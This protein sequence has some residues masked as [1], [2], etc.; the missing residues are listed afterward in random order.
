VSDTGPAPPDGAATAAE[1]P[2]A[3]DKRTL[4]I[5]AASMVGLILVGVVSAQLFVRGGCEPLDDPVAADSEVVDA[6]VALTDLGVDGGAVLD[7][8]G[9]ALGAGFTV[10]VEVGDATGITTGTDGLVVTG[11]R[12]TALA[13]DGTPSLGLATGGDVV[14]SGD[15]L[16][17]LNL[18]NPGTGQVDGFTPV[19]SADL[20]AGAC[21]DTAVVG[22]AF[23][24]LLDAGDG[25]VLLFRS[26]EDGAAAVAQLRDGDTAAWDLPLSLPAGSPGVL[27][28]RLTGALGP[29]RVV[30]ARRVAPD[31]P[32]PV[33]I[34]A[35]RADGTPDVE[36]SRDEVV[37]GFD[38][39]DDVAVRVA[40]HAVDDQRALLSAA[41]DPAQADGQ[42]PAEPATLGLLDL[43]DGTIE[44]LGGTDGRVVEAALDGDRFAAVLADG[45]EGADG[46]D[47]GDG[48]GDG[49]ILYLGEL[50]S[51]A[52][53]TARLGGQ[54]VAAAFGDGAALVATDRVLAR[55][56]WVDPGRAV[57]DDALDQQTL[58]EGVEVRDLAVAPD[59][60]LLALVGTGDRQVLLAGGPTDALTDG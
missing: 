10:G 33:V 24:F 6:E 58:P 19:A 46:A 44:R 25:Q 13:V 26:E 59:G 32:D 31:D 20:R 47:D 2:L 1:D 48:D 49:V 3:A 17:A 57:Q 16:Y 54:H 41:P 23:A 11:P 8:L 45:G 43:D 52:P 4:T 29:D 42:A 21:T 35:G 22:E 53:A 12:T 36:V 9:T 38:L 51:G 18:A 50:G 5:G 14:G 28:D 7:T 27:A 39:A 40:V 37:A 56:G 55:V 60:S 15:T 34:V 30:V